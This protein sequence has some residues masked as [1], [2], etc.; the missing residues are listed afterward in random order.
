[1]LEAIQASNEKKIERDASKKL[2]DN[3]VTGRQLAVGSRS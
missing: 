3:G 2:S 1:M